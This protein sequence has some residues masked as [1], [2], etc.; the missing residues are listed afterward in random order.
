ML[1]W[2]NYPG[3]SIHWTGKWTGIVEWT[4]ALNG[5]WY[6]CLGTGVPRHSAG[7]VGTFVRSYVVR[8]TYRLQCACA[9]NGSRELHHYSSEHVFI[10]LR[11][12]SEMIMGFHE[13]T[14]QGM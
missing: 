11:W 2:R 5:L 13:Y 10:A 1:G 6:F 12:R 7:G 14:Y 3:I 9:S 8:G 4:I